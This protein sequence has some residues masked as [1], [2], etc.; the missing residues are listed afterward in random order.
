M[1]DELKPNRGG[2]PRLV[3]PQNAE[4][5]RRLIAQECCRSNSSR[6]REHILRGLYRLLTAYERN[7]RNASG[8]EL[9]RVALEEESV[10]QKREALELAKQDQ[11]LRS[12][13]YRRRFAT[14]THGQQKLLKSLERLEKE[15]AALRLEIATGQKGTHEQPSILTQ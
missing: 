7:E 5:C 10:R 6:P 12:A 11:N 13:E 2:R 1:T 14:M 8:I 3:P 9:R 15:N 4:E